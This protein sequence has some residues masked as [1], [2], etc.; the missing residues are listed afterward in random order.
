F[1]L[2]VMAADFVDKLLTR[3]CE[4]PDGPDAGSNSRNGSSPAGF[5]PM[6][7]GFLLN[8]ELARVSPGIVTAIGASIGLAANTI[9]SRGSVE[10][11]ERWL[12]PL[13]TFEKV[14][15]WGLTEPGSGSDAFTAMKS[16]VRRD[17][18]GFRLNG[19]KTFITN[20]PYADTIVVF[21]KLDDG[22]AP[23][24][25]R[26]IVAFVLDSGMRGLTQG[27]PFRKMGCHSSPTG[28]LWFDDVYL[29]P[30]RQLGGA[31]DASRGDEKSGAKTVFVAERY[32]VAA[33]GL[34]II[35]ECI[36]QCVRYSKERVQ[37]G[38]P[39]ADYQLIQL[40]LARM[41]IARSNV[42]NSLFR[43]VEMTRDGHQPTLAEASAAKL[44]ASEAALEVALDA[45]QLFGGNGYMSEYPVEQ[46][47]RD[48]K[49]LAIYSGSNEIQ[50]TQ[51]AHDLLGR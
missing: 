11:K 28:E 30:D 38:K 35:E 27:N 50:T 3:Q 12:K 48:A 19:Q 33:V 49:V 1:G 16:T 15:A 21:A 45:V 42:A 2:D 37:F 13:M 31:R 39:I 29:E 46:L 26:K 14:G 18:Q 36:E 34:G 44:Y 6:A 22:V 47:A 5:D 17:G 32:G 23:A 9:M 25:E 41:E 8:A 43:A 24:R 4:R 20:A 10:Q 40:K 51:I 7:T